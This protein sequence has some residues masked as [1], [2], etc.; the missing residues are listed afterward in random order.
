V[1]ED[2]DG[3]AA[4]RADGVEMIEPV[5]T[6][7]KRAPQQRDKRVPDAGNRGNFQ[8]FHP[9]GAPVGWLCHYYPDG[10]AGRDA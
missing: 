1:P 2:H 7:A 4:V 3:L 10:A 5:G 9:R 6:P 8:A